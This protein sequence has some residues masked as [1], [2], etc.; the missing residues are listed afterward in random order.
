MTLQ[1]EV[2]FRQINNKIDIDQGMLNHFSD[3][4]RHYRNT[5]MKKN[6]DILIMDTQ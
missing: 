3:T 1:R 5:N 4:N 2:L 6:I